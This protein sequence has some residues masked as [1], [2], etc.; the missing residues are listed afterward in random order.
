MAKHMVLALDHGHPGQ[1]EAMEDHFEVVHPS[2][3]DP[4]AVIRAHQSEIQA[5]TSYLTPV[6]ASLISA[7]PALEIIALGAVGYDHVDVETA[8]SRG[9]AM[10]N[11][12]EVLTDD[13]ADIGMMLLLNV[14]RR[15]VEGDAFVRAGLWANGPLPLGHTLSGKKLGI[16]GMGRIG[17]AVAQRAKAFNM[18]VVY[19][20]P[21]KKEGLSEAFYPDLIQMARD[22]DFLMLCCVGGQT[23]ENMVDYKVLEALG[24]KGYVI[25]IARGSVIHQ[26]DLLIALSNKAI[27]GAGLDVYD[28]EPHVPKELFRMDNVVLTP[29][30]GSA[31][32]ETRTKMG[33]IVVGNLLA[34]FAGKPLL[35]PLA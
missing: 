11:T 30:I 7:L 1:L 6:G 19:H 12:P 20:G 22:V 17:Q 27:A 14:A 3:D 21:R 25:N 29:H 34:H 5:V 26:Q 24:P 35:T 10:T 8:K 31:T 32:I 2:R 28:N 15:S 23:T 18:E 4:E 16:V 33:Q 13:T 9:V